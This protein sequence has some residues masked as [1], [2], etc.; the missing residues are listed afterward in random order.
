LYKS[1]DRSDP[2]NYRLVHVTSILSRTLERVLNARIT[3]HM[4]DNNLFASTQAGFR[5]GH[6][7]HHQL[8]N[9]MQQV[10]LALAHRIPV[11][12]VF[13]DIVKAFDTIDVNILLAKLHRYGIQGN[14]LLWLQSF[15]TT[16][17]FQVVSDN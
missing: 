4:E 8:F 7:T 14:I 2:S 15:L 16:R 9:I 1:D 5:R 17:Q 6:S 3:N 11:P 10:Y 12:V 13:L